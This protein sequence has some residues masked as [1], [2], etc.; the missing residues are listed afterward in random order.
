[1]YIKFIN[2]HIQYDLM[3]PYCRIALP[4]IAT[5][6]LLMKVVLVSG[7]E[8]NGYTILEFMRVLTSCDQND[9]DVKV[10]SNY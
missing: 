6:P 5:F 8:E 9:L 7:E 4:L 3:R 10:H 2:V 1:M